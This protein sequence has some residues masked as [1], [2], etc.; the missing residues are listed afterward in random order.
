MM[1]SVATTAAPVNGV[2][3]S[4]LMLGVMY[5][6]VNMTK[7]NVNCQGR[8]GALQWKLGNLTYRIAQATER[9][10]YKR[11]LIKTLYNTAATWAGAYNRPT[12]AITNKWRS[13]ILYAVA[14][15]LPAQRSKMLAWTSIVGPDL[16]PIQE[17]TL[18]A[19]K[20]DIWQARQDNAYEYSKIANYKWTRHFEQDEYV[21]PYRTR[22]KTGRPKQQ[23]R[24]PDFETNYNKR[25]RLAAEAIAPKSSGQAEPDSVKQTDR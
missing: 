8:G 22:P 14:Q 12:K 5:F 2:T 6:L 16:D 11:N 7:L 10:D 17:I 21:P 23:K 3:S 4:Y 20:L 24:K 9:L 18:K 1:Q 19:V 13:A 15:Q 25:K